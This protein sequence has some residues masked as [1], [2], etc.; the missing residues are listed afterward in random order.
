MD[1]EAK[2]RTSKTT[3]SRTL[4]KLETLNTEI[5]ERRRSSSVLML[6]GGDEGG[7]RQRSSSDIN[8]VAQE[9]RLREAGQEGRRPASASATPEMKRRLANGQRRDVRDTES[10]DSLQLG[11]MQRQFTGSTGSLPSI[12]VSSVSDYCPT[13]D[14]RED[15]PGMVDQ[16]APEIKV[17]PPVHEDEQAARDLVARV[18][19][20]AA[21][22]LSA[23]QIQAPEDPE[24]H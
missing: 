18:L 5:H 7:D 20:K 9:A 17:L 8:L 23:D 16:S 2:I 13:P 11:D 12:G 24:S 21:A 15:P 14:T 19:E 10:L 3:Y 1:L 4:K 22:Q 6:R